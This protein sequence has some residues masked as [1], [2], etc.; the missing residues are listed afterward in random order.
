MS[1][2]PQTR[3]E[4]G[5]ILIAVLFTVAIMA[6]LVVAATALTRAGIGSE[7]LDQRRMATHFAL[8]SGLEIAKGMILASEPEDRLFFDGESVTLDVGQDVLISARIRDAASFIDLN[9][10]DPE[11][12]EAL[13]KLMKLDGQQVNGLAKRIAKLRDDATPEK[14]KPPAA[15]P[16]PA[17]PGQPVS[18]PSPNPALPGDRPPPPPVIFLAVEQIGELLDGGAALDQDFTANLTIFNPTGKINPMAAGSSVLQAVPGLTKPD[19]GVIAEA[20]QSRNAK[21]NARLQQILQR[22]KDHLSITEPKAFVIELRLE[23]GPNLLA[24]SQSRAVV[25]LGDG[26]LPFRT[27]AAGGE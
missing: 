18:P 4:R 14:D 19:L 11:L 12:I 25:L 24:G 20:R 5:V 17:Q 3:G 15:A 13:A 22:T 26:P 10:S 7:R 23:E 8:R 21:D 27:L 16:A 2:V 9:R 1:P 6:V